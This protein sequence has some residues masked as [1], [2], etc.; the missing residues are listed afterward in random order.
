MMED[1]IFLA[2]AAG[3]FDGEGCVLVNPRGN[4]K[5]HSLFTSVTQQDPTALHLL[6]QRFG[7]NVTPD[8][9]ATSDS[10]E[11]KRGA[12]LVWRWKASS[13]EA[14]AF[15]KSIEPYV[16]VKA[17]QVRVALEFPAVGTRF[18]IN[19]PIPEHVRAKREQVMIALRSIRQAQKVYLEAANG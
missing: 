4:G 11:R 2:W 18:C 15:L 3:F 16:V 8:K 12:V 7:G 10:Y 19:N 5:F 6:K 17:E 9:T 14:H 1:K 13:V